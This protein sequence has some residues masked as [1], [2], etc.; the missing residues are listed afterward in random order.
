MSKT[1]GGT[2]GYLPFSGRWSGRDDKDA[3]A[4][5]GANIFQKEARSGL[6][7]FMSRKPTEVSDM[8]YY[9]MLASGDY[10][11]INPKDR[12]MNIDKVV[13]GEYFLDRHRNG[14]GY[15]FGLDEKGTGGDVALIKK[16]DIVVK[17]D[18]YPFLK[19]RQELYIGKG[20]SRNGT[21]IS[22]T[23]R[24]QLYGY[25]AAAAKMGSKVFASEEDSNKFLIIDRSALIVK[26]RR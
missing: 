13:N 26:R 24:N 23:T 6:G 15:S 5:D 12:R 25:S 7:D 9:R 20:I 11:E 16:S 4:S 10:L 19:E 22:D 18:V 21:K 8:E 17:K 1:S 14:F 3:V 2:R